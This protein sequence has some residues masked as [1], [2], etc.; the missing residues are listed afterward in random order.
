VRK[1]ETASRAI[2]VRT[3]W[4][5]KSSGGDQITGFQGRWDQPI[6]GAVLFDMTDLA[7]LV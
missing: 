6:F 1:K 7:N 3:A 2:R 4:S 5:V